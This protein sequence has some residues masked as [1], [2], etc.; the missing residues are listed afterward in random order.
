MYDHVLCVHG[1][2]HTLCALLLFNLSGREQL[3]RR[4]GS[5]LLG[6]L[7][8]EALAAEQHRQD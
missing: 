7:Q 2:I 8:A 6:C 3:Q 5:S 1:L 4:E